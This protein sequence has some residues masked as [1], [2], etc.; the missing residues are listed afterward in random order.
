MTLNRCKRSWKCSSFC[1]ILLRRLKEC[2]RMLL[3]P[4]KGQFILFYREETD[5][6]NGVECDWGTGLYNVILMINQLFIKKLN[7]T[8]NRVHCWFYVNNISYGLFYTFSSHIWSPISL[9]DIGDMKNEQNRRCLLKK[10][11]ITSDIKIKYIMSLH[12]SKGNI[13]IDNEK[14]LKLILV[15]Q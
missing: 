3:M 9:S 1:S 8:S 12:N 2:H 10:R 4:L 5:L 6:C 13:S 11:Q 7:M 15:T 14:L